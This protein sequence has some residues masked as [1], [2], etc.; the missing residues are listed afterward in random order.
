MMA[1]LSAM[2]SPASCH[3]CLSLFLAVVNTKWSTIPITAMLQNRLG[4]AQ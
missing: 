1:A 4:D 3:V 2:E